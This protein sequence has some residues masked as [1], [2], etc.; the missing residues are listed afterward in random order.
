[1]LDMFLARVQAT[2][3]HN[4]VG[5]YLH[6]SL[7]CGDFDPQT[8]DIDFVVVTANESLT[9]MLPVLGAMHACIT[10]SGL[11]C[12]AKLEGPYI[13][14]QALRR[15][16]PKNAQH[17]SLRVD[18]SFGVDQYGS[19]WV[20]QRHI[21]REQGIVLAGP[22]PHTL[23]D[24]VQPDELRRAEQAMLVE[25]WAPQLDDPIRLVSPEY[26]AYATLTMC[27][28]LYTLQYATVV[29]KRV[30]ARWAQ[31]KLG[32]PWA[33]VIGRA[34]EWRCGAQSGNMDDKTDLIRYAL[35]RAQQF[36]GPKVAAQDS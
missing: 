35:E 14:R 30:A 7:A 19:D 1:M 2:L 9:E 36:E 8:S 5:L 34:L 28:A 20:I 12:A 10:A 16:D 22:A 3:G 32:E 33:A 23:I 25:W 4:F 13:P 27:R 26:Q 29:S 18:G 31:E 15:Y 17:P 6:G 21:I 11:D 24:P